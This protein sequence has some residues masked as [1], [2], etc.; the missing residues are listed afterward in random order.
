MQDRGTAGLIGNRPLDRRDLPGDT[1]GA[2][3]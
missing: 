3:E 2:G 1:P